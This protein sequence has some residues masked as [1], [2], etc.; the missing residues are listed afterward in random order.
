MR[1]KN[2]YTDATRVYTAQ[3]MSFCACQPLPTR[4]THT[5]TGAIKP[6]YRKELKMTDNKRNYW[7]IV[8]ENGNVVFDGT[9]VEC[10]DHL[11]KTFG[12]RTLKEIIEAGYKI[13]RIK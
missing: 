10:W 11:V 1:V 12:D 7:G 13:T 5:F 3:I 8:R 2:T 6:P 4:G 9:F